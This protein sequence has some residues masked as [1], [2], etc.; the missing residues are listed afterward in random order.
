[1]RQGK[2]VAWHRRQRSSRHVRCLAGGRQGKCYV[3]KREKIRK[4]KKG[5]SRKP[6]L[7]KKTIR[8]QNQFIIRRGIKKLKTCIFLKDNRKASVLLKK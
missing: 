4:K 5:Q 2:E 8:N 7:L 3:G 6:F 1:M